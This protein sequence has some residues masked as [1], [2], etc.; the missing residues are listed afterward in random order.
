MSKLKFDVYL[1][2]AMHKRL[3]KDVLT[4]RENAKAI[5]RQLGLRYYDPAE[6]ELI[7]PHL[8]IDAKPNLK[9][10][11]WYVRK[12]FKHLDQCRA[13][14]VL[15]GDQSSSGTAWETARMYFK[16]RRPIILVAPRMFDRQLTNFTT[17]LV[18]KICATQMAAF[19]YLKRR[20]K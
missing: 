6:D 8:V 1:A 15:T 12:D 11:K 7:K 19:R 18:T 17:V 14:V 13:I 2:G 20:V 9:R 3:G 5:C 10:M 4:E 16:H